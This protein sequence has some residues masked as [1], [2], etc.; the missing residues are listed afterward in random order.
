MI[1]K[2]YSIANPDPDDFD[3]PVDGDDGDFDEDYKDYHD[4]DF[5]FEKACINCLS[6]DCVDVCECCGMPLCIPCHE[7]GVGFCDDCPTEEWKA[8][9]SREDLPF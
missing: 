4:A 5:D 6:P 3:W 2:S 8:Q 1:H 7:L 9:Q